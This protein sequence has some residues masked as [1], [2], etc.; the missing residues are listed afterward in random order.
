MKTSHNAISLS[1]EI[2]EFSLGIVAKGNPLNQ[3]MHDARI[4]DVLLDTK[5]QENNSQKSDFLRLDL[6]SLQSTK[7]ER[8][9]KSKNTTFDNDELIW[10]TKY[11]NMDS[12]KSFTKDIKKYLK[13]NK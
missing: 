8:K 13:N 10:S 11:N 12:N 7:S 9:N 6:E 3:E 2:I 4:T 1:Q 5:S